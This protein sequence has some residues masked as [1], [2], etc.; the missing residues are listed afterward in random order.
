MVEKTFFLLPHKYH[1]RAV[2]RFH[3][4]D[5]VGVQI[6]LDVVPKNI[7]SSALGI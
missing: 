3:L 5:T 1:V 4:M 7:E 2:N 6:L